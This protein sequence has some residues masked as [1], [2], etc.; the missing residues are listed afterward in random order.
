MRQMTDNGWQGIINRDLGLIRCPD[1]GEQRLVLAPGCED[2]GGRD[3]EVCVREMREEIAR[4]K[5]AHPFRTFLRS[6]R[7]W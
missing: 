1:H 5:K 7:C 4:W 3:C 6:L 2:C